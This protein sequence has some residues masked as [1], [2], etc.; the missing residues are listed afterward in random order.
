M[1]R[2]I[3]CTFFGIILVSMLLVSPSMIHDAFAEDII[4][5]WV[6]NNAG[7]WADNKISE[8]E[9]ISGIQFLIKNGVI[10]ISDSLNENYSL[11]DI[12]NK[13]STKFRKEIKLEIKEQWHYLCSNFYN[14]EYL[15]Y[16]P[17]PSKGSGSHINEHGFRGPEIIKEKPVNTFRVFLVGTSTTFGS[18]SDDKTQIFSVLQKKFDEK[19]FEFDI[20]VINAGIGGGNWSNDETSLIKNKLIDFSPD[21]IVVFDSVSFIDLHQEGSKRKDKWSEICNFGKKNGFDTIIILQPFNGSGFRVLTENDQEIFLKGGFTN[22]A[23]YQLY[24]NQLQEL[25]KNCKKAVDMSRIFDKIPGDVFFDSVHFGAR[26]NQIIADNFYR[27]ISDSIEGTQYFESTGFNMNS[28]KDIIDLLSLENLNFNNANFENL[29]LSGIDFSERDLEN[30][31]FYNT[32]LDNV[33]FTNA[34]LSGANFLG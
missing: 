30:V 23:L 12:N 17:W 25:N 7:W 11:C 22:V 6:K 15:M 8:A 5:A 19:N 31:I 10:V 3:L 32:N 29:N 2:I 34:N 27:V 13:L 14:E 9:F 21:L 16:D 26:A 20:Q 24:S 28:K 33:D 1:K 4:P 18:G